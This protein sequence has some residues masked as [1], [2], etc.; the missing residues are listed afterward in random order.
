V[1]AVDTNILV[2]A[3]RADSTNHSAA[4]NT[5]NTLI[6]GGEE[7]A[8]PWTCVHEFLSTVTKPS[9]VNG[10]T[11]LSA[12]LDQIGEVVALQRVVLL[13]EGPGYFEHLLAAVEAGRTVGGAI[14]DA[15]IAALCSYHGI[16]ELL[17]ADRDFARFPGL[18][19]R[20]PLV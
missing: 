13:A 11:P 18:R 6:A 8:L 19:T 17:T 7:W 4:R 16:T 20:N 3:Y 9:M 1:I 5:V 15:R 10:P 12:A 14:H 2:Y